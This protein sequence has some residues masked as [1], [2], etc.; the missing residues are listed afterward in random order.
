M[1]PAHHGEGQHYDIDEPDE[2]ASTWQAPPAEEAHKHPVKEP[3]ANR[4]SKKEQIKRAC[5]DTDGEQLPEKCEKLHGDNDRPG[6]Q[7]A[8]FFC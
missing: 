5:H 1:H 8:L 7:T 3:V 6:H 4:Q 2:D